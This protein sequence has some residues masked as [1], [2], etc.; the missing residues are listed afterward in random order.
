M[1]FVFLQIN[2]FKSYYSKLIQNVLRARGPVDLRYYFVSAMRWALSANS[3]HIS[4]TVEDLFIFLFC[5][6]IS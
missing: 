5:I 1:Q 4:E 6:D 2:T 3:S